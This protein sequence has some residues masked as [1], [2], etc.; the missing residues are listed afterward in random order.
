MQY[1][2]LDLEW[3]QPWPGSPSARRQL[4]VQISGEII[5]VGAVRLKGNQSVADEFQT[6]IQPK[7][8]RRLNSR[9]SK[10]TGIKEAQLQAEGVPFPEAMAQFRAWC[11]EDCVFLTWGF[12]DIRMLT[13]NLKLFGM[14]SDWVQK[15]YNAQMIF[16]AQVGGDNAQKAL[17]TAMEIMKIPPT[18][19]AH[20]ALGDAYH[21]AVICSRLDLKRG[22]A[23]YG[24]SVRTHEDGL[25]GLELPDCI[26]RKVYRG[27]PDKAKAISEMSG[28]RNLCPKCGAR[29]S[30][31][32]WYSQPGKR[33]VSMAVC[34]T[35]GK[36]LVR[37]RLAKEPEGTLRVSRLIYPGS[38]EAAKSLERA[39]AAPKEKR[40][41]FSR[42]R[43]AKRQESDET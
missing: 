43:Q 35:H 30:G 10:L 14:E 5:Q 31:A 38:S 1:I 12:D 39:A 11:G 3:N 7:Y 27:Y 32:R 2:V 37:L 40:S 34:P 4:P 42:K 8:Y 28:S 19:P 25:S 6:L 23:E 17:G 9:V 41:L 33:Y 16:N 13:S 20:D 21:T 22:I 36:F 29:M 18:R 26:G 24:K 15:W